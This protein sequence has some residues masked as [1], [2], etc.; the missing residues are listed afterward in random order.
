[1]KKVIR[2][3]TNRDVWSEPSCSIS[4]NEE[5][6]AFPTVGEP[7]VKVTNKVSGIVTWVR[8]SSVDFIDVKEVSGDE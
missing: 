4:F 6:N 3:G 1:M 8:L 2:I 5:P 7:F